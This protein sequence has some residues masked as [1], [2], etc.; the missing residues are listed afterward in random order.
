MVLWDRCILL[1]VQLRVMFNWLHC[2]SPLLSDPPTVQVQVE[3]FKL[4]KYSHYQWK[5]I[6]TV[7]SNSSSPI[8]VKLLNLGQVY[9]YNPVESQLLFKVWKM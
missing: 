4:P 8:S 6:C 9:K 2:S 3:L 1:C 7:F 5:L